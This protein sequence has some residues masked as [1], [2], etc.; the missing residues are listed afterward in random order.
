MPSADACSVQ[1]LPLFLKCGYIHL[2]NLGSCCNIGEEGL[3]L[4]WLRQSL[5]HQRATEPRGISASSVHYRLRTLCGHLNGRDPWSCLK[6]ALVL[7]LSNGLWG[8][9]EERCLTGVAYRAR[10]ESLDDA[11]FLFDLGD[12]L[13]VVELFEFLALLYCFVKAG[14]SFKLS[15]DCAVQLIYARECFLSYR[16]LMICE[17]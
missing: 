7:E 5:L 8:P 9:S 6:A 17:E 3:L 16:L 15:K 4:L 12:K 10:L 11:F 13:I 1:T 14:E 2:I